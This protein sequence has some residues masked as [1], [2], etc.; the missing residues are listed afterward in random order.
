LQRLISSYFTPY[1]T[2]IMMLLVLLV[3]VGYILFI[4][5]FRSL[6]LIY[7]LC[8]VIQVHIPVPIFIV[9]YASKSYV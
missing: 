4:L 5:M 8:I 3:A 1:D 9:S 7:Q 2:L 6:C